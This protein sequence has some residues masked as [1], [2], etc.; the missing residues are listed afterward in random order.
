M[1]P[2]SPLSQADI[3]AR[4]PY[5]QTK[6]GEDI[7]KGRQGYLSCFICRLPGDSPGSHSEDR[8][9]TFSTKAQLQAFSQSSRANIDCTFKVQCSSF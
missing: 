4:G 1:K 5:S 3:K 6:S 7:V 2:P 8:V 9:I